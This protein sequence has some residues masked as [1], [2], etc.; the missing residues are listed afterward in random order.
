MDKEVLGTIERYKKPV[1]IGDLDFSHPRVIGMIEHVQKL[2]LN[3]PTHHFIGTFLYFYY[4]APKLK[5]PI[6]IS[7]YG[8]SITTH[9]GQGRL[10]GSYFRQDKTI[11]ALLIPLHSS[12]TE[13]ELLDAIS[14]NK[15]GFKN[16]VF[17]Y[18]NKN[19]H[20]ISTTEF[21]K[22]FHPTQDR[23]DYELE[24]D[25]LVNDMLNKHGRIKWNIKDRD[26]ISLG[27]GKK[28]KVNITCD[29]EGFYHSVF[30]LAFNHYKESKKFKILWQ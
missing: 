24:K 9:P 23:I 25:S 3:A 15:K 13:I 2:F 1:Y 17:S 6:T 29:V 27:E 30:Y 20:G 16:K 21:K 10:L 19:H 8:D 7:A 11:P 4:I 14:N 28:I 12:K 5:S 18:N 26:S 22:Y